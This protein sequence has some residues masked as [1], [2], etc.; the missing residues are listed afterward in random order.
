MLTRVLSVRIAVIPLLTLLGY[1]NAPNARA[2]DRGPQCVPFARTLSS[3]RLFGDA[4][5]WWSAATGH[6]DRGVTPQ[7]GSVL[8]FRADA[9]MPLGHVAV[10]TR[11]INT[12]EIEV[13]HANWSLPG[14]ITREVP[15]LDV[16]TNND[17]TMVRVGLYEH[18][19]FGAAY[20]T[21]GFIYGW[22][23]ELGSQIIDVTEALRALHG[24][25]ASVDSPGSAQRLPTVIEGGQIRPQQPPSWGRAVEGLPVV[26][27]GG[28][29]VSG[30]SKK[31]GRNQL[32]LSYPATVGK[33]D[34]Q[35]GSH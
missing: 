15:V 16:S 13:D 21:N 19:R 18:D 7:A 4:W 26:L 23:L 29:T 34:P 30:P 1:I 17:W 25:V 8:S 3:I 11:V 14:A 9:R 20:A 33:S 12:R 10:V 32:A 6:Y 31:R 2:W 22:P 27:T 28:S 35:Q 5:R 24:A